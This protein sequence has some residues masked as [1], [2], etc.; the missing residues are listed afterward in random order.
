MHNRLKKFL[1]EQNIF[2]LK[3]FVFRKN[4]STTHANINLIDSTENAT[5][6]NKF[7]CGVF[8]DLKEVIDTVDHQKKE[9]QLI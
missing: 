6:Q 9:S 7:A 3:Q 1:T 2:H 4:F 5:D 8:I